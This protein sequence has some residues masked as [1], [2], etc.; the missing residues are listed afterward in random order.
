[1]KKLTTALAAIALGATCVS[2]APVTN[3]GV[4]SGLKVTGVTP[5][6]K[7]AMATMQKEALSG[8]GDVVTRGFTSTDGS[9]YEA[10]FQLAKQP[11]NE[12]LT[13]EDAQGNPYHP[14]FD[15]MPYYYAVYTLTKTKP[16]SQD[17]ST[18]ITFN[19][20][21]P[22]EYIYE[23]VWSYKGEVNEQGQI[24]VELR[25]YEPVTMDLLANN[26]NR[27]QKFQEA[28]FVGAELNE[29]QTKW[30]YY[31]MLPNELLGDP[32]LYD[33]ILGYTELNDQHAS[34]LEFTMYDEEESWLE[35]NNRIYIYLPSTGSSRRVQCNYKGTGSVEG[36]AP[37]IENLPNFG[38]VH[39]FNTGVLSS[40]SMGDNNPFPGDFDPLTAFYFVS[41]DQY[42]EWRID[43][44]AGKFDPAQIVSAGVN[45]PV[46]ETLR[47][48]A[49]YIRGYLFADKKFAGDDNLNPEDLG[50]LMLQPEVIQESD[51]FWYG[52]IVPGVNTMLPYAIG[53]MNG[54]MEPWSD[55]YG[56]HCL[57]HNGIERV[58]EPSTLGWGYNKGLVVDLCNEFQKT[59]HIE[60]TGKLI[61]HYDPNNMTLFRE[62]S[63]VGG[64]EYN[65]VD[66][67]SVAPG[68]V[69]PVYFDLNGVRVNGNNLNK[70]LY[71][72][73]TGNKAEKV[74]VK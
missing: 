61:Y 30:A 19:L 48:H 60:S 2:A 53:D 10:R 15:A 36:F 21:W 7:T 40:E 18:Y 33:D 9:Y 57:L 58:Y 73:V 50:F 17:V 20:A 59:F 66:E 35:I 34:T 26:P 14:T 43:P 46:G 45:L 70:G 44:S 29:G 16:D 23:Q 3:T 11:L 67:I 25:E 22:S 12:M 13:F 71:I 62:L 41:G 74:L 63:L 32:C 28:Q 68:N 64:K 49:N 5:A 38:D 72:K 47:D 37:I 69:A 39:L 54:N 27:C 56:L 51:D 52:Y 55:T 24:P 6:Y 42:L 4:V 65:S 8:E 1:M 31:T